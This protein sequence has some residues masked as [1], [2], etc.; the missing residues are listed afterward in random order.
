M[1]CMCINI[2]AGSY[3]EGLAR[4]ELHKNSLEGT[5]WKLQT[6]P[7][8]DG[9]NTGKIQNIIVKSVTATS[10]GGAFIQLLHFNPGFTSLL[11]YMGVLISP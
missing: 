5:Q 4:C 11:L 6:A 3:I 2:N 10:A 9:C 7:R 8:Q 1:L